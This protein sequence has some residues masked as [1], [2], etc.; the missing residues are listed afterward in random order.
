[1]QKT[2]HKFIP[3]AYGAYFNSLALFSQQNTAKKA[4]GLFC[5]PRK[6]KVLPEQAAFLDDA[7]HQRVKTM[8]I[9]LQTYQWK[10]DRETVL[11]LHGWESNTFRWRNLIAFLKD[12]NYNIVA[13]DAPAHGNSTGNIFNV[14]LYTE[15][16]KVIVDAY[17][18]QIIIGHSVGGMNTLYHQEKYPNPEIEKIVTI[19][20]PSKLQ[21]VMQHYQ[22]ILKFN[23]VV[24]EALDDYILKNYG[25]RIHEFNSSDFKGHLDKKGLIIHDRRDTIVP[26]S[27]SEGVHASWKNSA[28]YITEGFGHSMHQKEVNLRI[29]DFIK[30]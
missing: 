1:M 17:K 9:E 13:F 12:E 14:A 24:Y 25:F 23:D 6:G 22:Q 16:T 30:S 8:N 7:R 20:S 28:F 3:L 18:P 10:G 29:M 15:C 5:S 19:G 2:L 4:F 26:F 11:L 21:D 27:A